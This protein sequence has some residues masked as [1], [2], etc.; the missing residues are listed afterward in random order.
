MSVEFVDTNVVA[1]SYD[2]S[3][4]SKHRQ[5]LELI[6]RLSVSGD[7]ALSLQVLQELF[8]TLTRKFRPPYTPEQ[9]RVVVAGLATWPHVVEPNR[10]DLLDAV[11]RSIRMRISF[12]DALIVTAAVKVQATVLWSED[13][14]DGQVYDGVVV[15]NPFAPP[16]P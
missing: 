10:Q 9:G 3:S 1:Y 16:S 6:E 12:W 7:G 15:R 8:V 11:D 5:A 4:G 14:N 2:R 13:L